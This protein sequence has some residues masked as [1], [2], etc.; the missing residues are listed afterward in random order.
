MS[1]DTPES[2]TGGCL[3]GAIRY[4][5][6]FPPDHP[7]KDQV[8]LPFISIIHT[9]TPSSISILQPPSCSSSPSSSSSSSSSISPR[10]CF[11]RPCSPSHSASRKSSRTQTRRPDDSS[12]I[13]LP[14]SLDD[15]W[16]HCID[17]YGRTTTATT[18]DASS[19]HIIR[20]IIHDPSHINNTRR[21][22]RDG[23]TLHTPRRPIR[24]GSWA[25]GFGHRAHVFIA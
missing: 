12:P 15:D 2:I 21:S 14:S 4:T 11:T 13:E 8:R 17:I 20:H 6:T 24:S 25:L 10:P 1:S 18:L 22:G 9:L 19:Y 16:L 5:I 23:L 7:F 3:C